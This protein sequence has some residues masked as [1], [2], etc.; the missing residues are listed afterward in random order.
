MTG[1]V[2][3]QALHA[4]LTGLSTRQRALAD[5][6]AN[7]NT[8]GYSAHRVMFEDQLRD[9]LAS[10][11]SPLVEPTTARSMEPAQ[12]NGNN[13]NLDQASLQLIDTN[14]RYQFGVEALT[15]KYNLLRTAMKGGS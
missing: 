3:M 1:D 11:A 8:P 10:G 12:E 2:T 6:I 15:A 9:A 14:L 5:D 4:T 13:V 7:I